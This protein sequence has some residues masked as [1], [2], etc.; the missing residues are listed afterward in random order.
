MDLIEAIN[1]RH[2]VRSFTQSMIE[3]E[4]VAQLQ[5]LVKKFNAE[6]SLHIQLV[7][8]EPKA[9]AGKLASYGKFSGVRNYFALIGPKGNNLNEK[10]GFYGELLVLHAQAMG[11]NTCW[12]GLTYSKI[13]SALSINPGEKLVCVIALGYGT[14]Q[15]VKHKIKDHNSVCR[16]KG[17]APVWFTRG[18][19]A[20]LL[21]PT[22]I[23]QQK[24]KF[25]LR[26][27]NVVEVRKGIGPYTA[28]DL[29][30]VKCH[31]QL[32]AGEQNF[33]WKTD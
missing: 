13:K 24:F 6:A 12:V 32:A 14:T 27:N 16:Y 4:K 30:I 28:V 3:P 15:G 20:A 21:A 9:F 8:E 29:G 26:E 31:F 25:I 1:K 33:S 23:N 2:S 7:V 17:T 11:L 18:V 19:D 5:Q 10:L 22:A